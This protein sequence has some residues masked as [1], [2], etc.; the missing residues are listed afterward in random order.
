[1]YNNH[2]FGTMHS[3]QIERR[4]RATSGRWRTS[5]GVKHPVTVRKI[6]KAA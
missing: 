2:P 1:M 3:S 6:R 5:D 4:K